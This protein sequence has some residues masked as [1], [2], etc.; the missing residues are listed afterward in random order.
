MTAITSTIVDADVIINAVEINDRHGVGILLQRIFKDS[1]NIITLRALNLYGGDNALGI[2][3]TL[4]GVGLSR[5]DIFQKVRVALTGHTVKRILCIPYHVDEIFAALAVQELFGAE[6]CTYLMDDQNILSTNIT[7][8]AMGELLRKSRL[9]LAIS[10]EMRDIYTNKY[11]VDIYFAPP[12]IPADLVNTEIP[13]IPAT[14]E[15]EDI[16]AIF[17]NIWSS[18]WLELLRSMTRE[19]GVKLDWYGNTGADWNFRDR[20]ALT[21]DGI[22]EQGFLPTEAEVAKVLRNHSYV[23]I[24]SGTLDRRDDNKATS[25]MSLPSRIPFVLATSNTPAIVLGNRN[26]A[27]ARFVERFGI[28]IVSDYDP[29]S[30]RTAVTYI[31]QHN[32]QSQFRQN[33]VKVAE[34]FVNEEMDEWIWQSLLLGKPLDSR[35]E[36]LLVTKLDNTSALT[37]ALCIIRD[38][39]AEIARLQSKLASITSPVEYLKQ[40]S[41]RWQRLRRIW[42]RLKGKLK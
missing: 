39:E 9:I 20:S 22:I 36:D 12:V 6:I 8:E 21:A 30:F 34:Q 17:G 15:G 2:Y 7:N 27:A 23:V 4:I 16:G 3:D 29:V 41:Q 28:G 14:N 35:F 31:T 37:T 33:A 18:Q 40:N 11:G 42:L 25:W 10:P 32:V 5:E 24:P 13:A 19:A 1:S 26:T 38:R